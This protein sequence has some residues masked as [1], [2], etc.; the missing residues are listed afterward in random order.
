[1]ADRATRPGSRSTDDA[2]TIRRYVSGDRDGVLSLYETVFGDS[3]GGGEWF[4]WKFVDNPYHPDVPIFVA[5]RDGEVVGA[6]PSL[7]LPL[8]VGGERELALVQ[9]DPM[10]HPD[11]RRRGLFTRLAAA[12]YDHY[13]PR[14]PSVVVGFPNEAV[15][16]GLEKLTEE[17]SL[18]EGILERFP[19]YY[20]VQNPAALV[21]AAETDL[22]KRLATRLG[23]GVEGY[24][25]ARDRLGNATAEG[26][27]ERYAGT[28]AALLAEVAAHRPTPHATAVR[29]RQ[30]V[31]W[32]FRNPRYSYATYVLRRSGVPVAALVV[33]EQRD[34]GPDVAHVSD[35]LPVGGGRRRSD[36]LSTLLGRVVSD[37]ADADLLA[38]AGR[39]IPRSVLASHGF[40]G[41]D[42]FPLSRFTATYWFSARPITDRGVDEWVLNGHHLA[43]S[44]AWRLSFCELEVG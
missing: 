3:R 14:E 28:P 15:K 26:R 13:G 23:A 42:R 10:V 30:F 11:H 29:N 7:P 36:R 37:Y 16:G 34:V 17:L 18:D 35:A 2:Y 25:A 5:E 6:R 12:V 31:E 22:L 19:E 27:V 33:G 41:N 8:S 4:D 24:L 9:V 32:R 1:M 40:V 20:R 21:D 44:D 38:A 39:T 43:D